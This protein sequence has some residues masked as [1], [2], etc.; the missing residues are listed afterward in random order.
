[1][2]LQYFTIFYI[3]DKGNITYILLSL[4]ISGAGYDT[5]MTAISSE[6]GGRHDIRKKSNS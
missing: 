5:I 3:L 4:F 1:M 6:K 2:S